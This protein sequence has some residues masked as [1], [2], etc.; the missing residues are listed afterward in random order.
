V[1]CASISTSASEAARAQARAAAPGCCAE[2]L[3]TW[4]TMR[5]PTRRP[6]AA[7]PCAVA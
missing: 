5:W 1:P 6:M 7:S 2:C 4:S 3:P